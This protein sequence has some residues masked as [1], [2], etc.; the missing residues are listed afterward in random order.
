[1]G[2]LGTVTK[3]LVQELEDLE[4]TGREETVQ[5]MALLRAA[6]ILRRF[7]DT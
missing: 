7:L 3:Q 6:R 1:M 5:T 4:I 2:A